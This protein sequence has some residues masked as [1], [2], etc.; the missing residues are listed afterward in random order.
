[1]R[2]RKI[3]IPADYELE[4]RWIRILRII[5]YMAI[6]IVAYM[7]IILVAMEWMAGCGETFYYA[8]RTWKTGECIFIPYET[9]SG[10]W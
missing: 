1:M 4:S 10:T 2:R 6:G 3:Y 8:D 7:T 5:G 9:K